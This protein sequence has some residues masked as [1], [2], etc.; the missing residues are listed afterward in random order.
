MTIT[1][2]RSLVIAGTAFASIA[3]L[4]ITSPALANAPTTGDRQMHVAYGD[5][6]LASADGGKALSRRIN[7]AANQVCAP[8]YEGNNI[9]PF[10]ACT[11]AAKRDAGRQLA[12]AGVKAAL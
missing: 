6:D 12:A 8:T 7:R 4:A 9:F 5:L 10:L 3:S 2:A 1:F 11:D